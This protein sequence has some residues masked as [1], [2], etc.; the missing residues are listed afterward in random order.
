TNGATSE[1]VFGSQGKVVEEF[2]LYP[3]PNSGKFTVSVILSEAKDISLKLI[4]IQGQGDLGDYQG[5]GKDSYEVSYDYNA[6]QSGVYFLLLEVDGN[7][8][9]LK[10]IIN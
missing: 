3:N 7:S 2:K 5:L 8:Q 6:L 1:D 9:T 4:D 10:V